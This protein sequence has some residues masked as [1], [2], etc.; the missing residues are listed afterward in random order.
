MPDQRTSWMK[1]Y[2]F[3]HADEVY[4]YLFLR[5]F[6]QPLHQKKEFSALVNAFGDSWCPK[7]LRVSWSCT[8]VRCQS[9][10]WRKN[11]FMSWFGSSSQGLYAL[12]LGSHF[13]GFRWARHCAPTDHHHGW[14]C[15]WE[16]RSDRGQSPSH[17]LPHCSHSR[18]HSAGGADRSCSVF[19]FLEFDFTAISTDRTS[20]LSPAHIL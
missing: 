14:F 16:A 5:H 11:R 6:H 17:Q 3:A 19:L 20:L 18:R 15:F 9:H 7:C 2:V 13:A 8:A 4:L 10:L 12:T 1:R